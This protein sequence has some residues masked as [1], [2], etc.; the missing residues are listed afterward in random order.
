M[1]KRE[2]MIKELRH[3]EEQLRSQRFLV[4]AIREL[5]EKEEVE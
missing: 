3:L 4:K 1:M 2:D 5:L